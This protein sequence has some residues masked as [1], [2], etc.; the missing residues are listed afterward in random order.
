MKLLITGSKGLIGSALKRALEENNRGF[1]VYYTSRDD[2]DLTNENQVK[3]VFETIKPDY[4]INTAASVGGM[5]G[6]MANHAVYFRNNTLI[7]IHI[8]HYAYLHGVKKLLNMSSTCIFPVKYETFDETMLHDGPPFDTHFA[9]AHSKRMIDVQCRAYELQYGI[10]NYSCIIPGNVFGKNDS[11]N[12]KYGHVVASL[13]HKCYLARVNNTPFEIWGNGSAK[14]EFIYADD[15]ATIMLNLLGLEEIPR[16]VLVCSETELTIKELVSVI[17]KQM[18]FKGRVL[19]DTS[20]SNGQMRKKS[21]TT[22]LKLLLPHVS[23]TDF[24]K[25]IKETAGW[26]EE[27]YPNIRN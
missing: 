20:K 8:T 2:A 26:F 6:N 7:N 11:F 15:I 19:W 13:I 17:C 4:V 12:L 14:R 1:T 9:Y 3:K 18:S 23:F 27:N 16:N 10:K 5:G 21:D 22:L 24:G 25:A